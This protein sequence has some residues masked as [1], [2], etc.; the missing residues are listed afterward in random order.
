VTGIIN[1]CEDSL[2]T[3]YEIGLSEVTFRDL[4]LADGIRVLATIAAPQVLR[5]APAW[6]PDGKSIATTSEEGLAR[7][8][9]VTTGKIRYTLAGHN[10]IVRHCA[11]THDGKQ[12]LTSGFDGTIRVWDTTSGEPDKT[13]TDDAPV[14]YLSVLGDDRTVISASQDS[15]LRFWNLTQGKLEGYLAGHTATAWVTSSATV[16]GTSTIVSGST[17]RIAKIWDYQ[18]GEVR[19]TLSGHLLILASVAITSDARIVASGA[20]DGEVIIWDAV[21][22]AAEY[23]IPGTSAVAY[24]I[25]FSPDNTLLA[26]AR[27]NH[28]VTLYDVATGKPARQFNRGGWCVHFS[29]DGKLLA[30]GSD[31]RTVRIWKLTK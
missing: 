27:G 13:L 2:V 8:W 12:L 7:L 5:V 18:S 1:F 10:G 16:N 24:D 28:T 4:G 23:K 17:D 25:A 22:G 29:K 3:P 26:V 9:D 21:T 15:R 20:Q 31:D 14:Y 30:S 19:H 6:S 11:F